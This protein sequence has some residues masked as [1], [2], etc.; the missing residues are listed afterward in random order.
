MLGLVPS[1]HGFLVAENGSASASSHQLL[2]PQKVE[3]NKHGG[4]YRAS[5]QRSRGCPGQARA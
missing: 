2:L 1:I 3:S 4:S 5:A